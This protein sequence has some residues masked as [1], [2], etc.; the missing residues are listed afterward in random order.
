[1]SIVD[2]HISHL[3]TVNNTPKLAFC[4]SRAKQGACCWSGVVR[5]WIS[6]SYLGTT[7]CFLPWFWISWPLFLPLTLLLWSLYLHLIFGGW[8]SE[9]YHTVLIFL[10]LLVQPSIRRFCKV[11]QKKF[12]KFLGWSLGSLNV[13]NSSPRLFIMPFFLNLSL[14]A[15]FVEL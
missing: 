9:R 15:I 11:F 2:G 3:T 14:M 5:C 12:I 1:M 4:S 8:E 7:K 6:I 10:F 13:Y